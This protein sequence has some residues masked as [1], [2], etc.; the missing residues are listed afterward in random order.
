MWQQQRDARRGWPWPRQARYFL[1]DLCFWLEER[2]MELGQWLNQFPE[3]TPEETVISEIRGK[4]MIDKMLT[5]HRLRRDHPC[6]VCNGRGVVELVRADTV[7]FAI[8]DRC[9]DTGI[10][11][12]WS[13]KP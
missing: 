12:V 1:G 9:Q 11:P 5:R 3:P 10:D 2:L 4:R 13:G 8:C 6:P 7:D